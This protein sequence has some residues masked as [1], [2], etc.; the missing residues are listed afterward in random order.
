MSY[1]NLNSRIVEEIIYL[2][3]SEVMLKETLLV[4]STHCRMILRKVTRIKID[5]HVGQRMN[6]DQSW[7]TTH[8]EHSD[9]VQYG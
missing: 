2:C 5:T 3:S 6:S 8:K 9:E 7:K 1:F 4:K